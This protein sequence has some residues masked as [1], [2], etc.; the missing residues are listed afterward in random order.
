[1]GKGPLKKFLADVVVCLPES[2]NHLCPPFAGLDL[3]AK[4]CGFSFPLLRQM[5]GDEGAAVHLHPVLG[6]P[7][8]GSALTRMGVVEKNVWIEERKPF[9]AASNSFS[10]NSVPTSYTAMF[11]RGLVPSGVYF[12]VVVKYPKML[13]TV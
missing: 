5:K 3:N 12:G 1:M 8:D 2:R 4:K 6:L 13:S 7:M 10:F 11:C 9:E